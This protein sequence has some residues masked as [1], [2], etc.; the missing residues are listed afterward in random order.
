MRVVNYPTPFSIRL[1]PPELESLDKVR[2]PLAI[3]RSV[4]V[5]QAIREFLERQLI[6]QQQSAAGG[7]NSLGA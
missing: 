2:E 6:T 4:L 7:T 5:R 3:S 1:P